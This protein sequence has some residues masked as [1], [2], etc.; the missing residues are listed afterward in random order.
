MALLLTWRHP[1]CPLGLKLGKYNIWDSHDFVLPKAI[2]AV[3]QGNYNLMLLTV[4]K[5]PD[6][7]YYHNNPGYDL[8][9]SK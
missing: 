5:I 1:S 2:Y 9:Y 8:F 7:V 3:K 6:M 4:T